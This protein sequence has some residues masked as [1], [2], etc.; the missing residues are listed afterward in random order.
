MYAVVETG[1][2]Q[3]RVGPGDTIEVDKLSGEVGDTVRLNVLLLNDDTEVIIGAPWLDETRV[4]AQIMAHTR[5]KK[6]II[7]KHKR[8]KGY[9]RK[10]G[11]RQSFTALRI[12]GIHTATQAEAA[13]IPAAAEE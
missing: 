9:R 5:G 10:Q 7:F 1:G 11:H 2:R 4:E 12:T 13:P 6:I 3:Y 8:R